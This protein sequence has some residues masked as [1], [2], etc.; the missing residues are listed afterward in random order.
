MQANGGR[1]LWV[2]TQASADEVQIAVEDSGGGVPPELRE[3]IFDA[4][5]T[6]KSEGL[7]MGLSI[8]RSIVDA[9]GGRLWLEDGRRGTTFR[10]SLPRKPV[11]EQIRDAPA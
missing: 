3:R 1:D 7:G 4:F 6:T 11:L 2:R 8:S 10:F 9:H 5:F